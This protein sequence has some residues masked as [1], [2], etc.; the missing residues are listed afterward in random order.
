MRPPTD[1]VGEQLRRVAARSTREI[2]LRRGRDLGMYV[3]AGYPKSGTVWLCQLLGTY[4]GV[5]FPRDYRMPIAMASVIHAHWRYDTRLPPASYIRRDGRD[6]MVSLYFF[7]TR[8]L[9]G[10][11]KPAR[12]AELREIFE[13]LYGPRFDPAAVR[14]NLPRF[15]EWQLR[16]PRGSAGLPWHQ[17]VADWWGRPGVA[18]VSYEGL[19]AEPATELAGAMDTMTG[20]S[21]PEV[22]ELATR[23]WSF[24]LASGRRAGQEDRG[25]FLRKGVAG[26]W[27]T[28]FGPES[29]EVF[30]AAA[31][32]ALVELGYADDRDWW[33]G[34]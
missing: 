16:E 29:G 9:E 19:L 2:V 13:G 24:A 33:R 25:S 10:P 34:L 5:P 11:A 30:D 4:L 27:R 12:A 17:H 1:R 7:Y 32:D 21:D 6:V 23:R 3:G 31:G 14:D 8:A 22:A 18:Q 20:G 26:D 15:I 28:H